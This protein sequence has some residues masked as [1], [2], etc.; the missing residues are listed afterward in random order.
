MYDFA[1]KMNFDLKAQGNKSTW[2]RILIK[3][4]KWPGLMDSVSGVSKTI[5]LLLILMNFVID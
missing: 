5:I 4:L 1:K 3:L 2:D